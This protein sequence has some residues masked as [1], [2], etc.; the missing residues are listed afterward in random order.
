MRIMHNAA[1]GQTAP[2]LTHKD[3]RKIGSYGAE[4]I[5]ETADFL[6]YT[7]GT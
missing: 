5:F 6:P 1:S 4:L 2:I 7:K 3:L